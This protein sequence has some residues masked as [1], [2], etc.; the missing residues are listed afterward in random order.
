MYIYICILYVSIYIFRSINKFKKNFKSASASPVWWRVFGRG[1]RKGDCRVSVELYKLTRICCKNKNN[2]I[3]ITCSEVC[4]FQLK[5]AGW[6]QIR[7]ILSQAKDNLL[8]NRCT[9]AKKKHSE[10]ARTGYIIIQQNIFPTRE[11]VRAE[12]NAIINATRINYNISYLHI[13]TLNE[14]FVKNSNMYVLFANELYSRPNE[15]Y[16]TVSVK[17]WKQFVFTSVTQWHLLFF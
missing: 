17:D 2:S 11:T 14:I 10:N 15:S 7:Y 9:C 1:G 6:I 13:I 4:S 5:F 8:V 12:Q 3:V 16:K